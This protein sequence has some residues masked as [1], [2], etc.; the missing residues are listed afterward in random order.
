MSTC[1]E[2]VHLPSSRTL[3][4]ASAALHTLSK[5]SIVSAGQCVRVAKEMDSKSM[6]LCLREFESPRCRSPRFQCCADLGIANVLLPGSCTNLSRLR[7]ILGARRPPT[8]PTRG[9][10]ESASPRRPPAVSASENCDKLPILRWEFSLGSPIA[11]RS[12]DPP[13]KTTRWGPPVGSRI[14][15]LEFPNG[16]LQAAFPIGIHQWELR[17]RSAVGVWLAKM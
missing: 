3:L 6:G 9:P 11:K 10:H 5:Y 1:V 7:G 8:S 2:L 13:I 15:H 14:L 17:A 4:P 12:W 16:I